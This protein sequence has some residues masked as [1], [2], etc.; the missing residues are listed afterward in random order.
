MLR[1][2][3]VFAGLV[4]AAIGLVA[5]A[6]PETPASNLGPGRPVRESVYRPAEGEAVALEAAQSGTPSLAE[7]LKA[8]RGG[9][10]PEDG[11]AAP[12][13]RSTAPATLPD[14]ATASQLP[15]VLVRRGS[16]AA[17]EPAA[18]VTDAAE[19]PHDDD[20]R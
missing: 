10:A 15:S 12:T 19:S 20:G 9:G 14:D 2:V 18:P 6:E 1:N 7:R 11:G 17:G 13:G 16:S 5:A 3:A 4:V 8:I